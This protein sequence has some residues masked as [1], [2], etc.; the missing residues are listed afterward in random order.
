MRTGFVCFALS[1][2]ALS[3]ICLCVSLNGAHRSLCLNSS[4]GASHR[5]QSQSP[6]SAVLRGHSRVAPSS[7]PCPAPTSSRERNDTIHDLT[8]QPHPVGTKLP[9]RHPHLLLR[10]TNN[11]SVPSCTDHTLG[12][13]CSNGIRN[14]GTCS[15]LAHNPWRR[16]PIGF[17]RRTPSR[18][19]QKP[20]LD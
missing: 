6:R 16:S 17:A 10:S 11:E 4:H 2:A 19:R 8:N 3:R 15:L 12:A 20:F 5:T 13:S 14:K 7:R 18:F 1:L 9:I